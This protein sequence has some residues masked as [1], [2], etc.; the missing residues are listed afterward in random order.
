MPNF[1][2]IGRIVGESDVSCMLYRD[3]RTAE[4]AQNLFAN[5]ISGDPDHNGL[6]NNLRL[7]DIQ[8]DFVLQSEST[9]E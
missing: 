2:V 1:A 9:I 6:R 5:W 8:F 7:S 3:A 4:E